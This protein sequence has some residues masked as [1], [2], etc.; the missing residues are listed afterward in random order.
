MKKK[1]T[2]ANYLYIRFIFLLIMHLS[3]GLEKK[4]VTSLQLYL[5]ATIGDRNAGHLMNL[6]LL[7]ST[8]SV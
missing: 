7:T 5:E 3:Q 6:L 1:L 8:Y 2:F 4:S